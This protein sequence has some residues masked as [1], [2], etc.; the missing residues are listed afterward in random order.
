MRPTSFPS[1]CAA[2]VLACTLVPIAAACGQ[3]APQP[4]GPRPLDLD[5][6]PQLFLDD[7]IVDRIDGLKRQVQQPRRLDQPVLD[8]KTFGTT[9][10]YLTVLYDAA[11]K[12]FRI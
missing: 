2:A 1:V 4:T 6:G 7:Y 3:G 5:A 10:P 9:Q 8:S 12:R 11:A